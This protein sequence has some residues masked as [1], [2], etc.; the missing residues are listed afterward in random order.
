MDDGSRSAREPRLSILDRPHRPRVVIGRCS[1]DPTPPS[2]TRD[3][4]AR[5]EPR[6]RA[7]RG[8][9]KK[10]GFLA[11]ARRQEKKPGDPIAGSAGRDDAHLLTVLGG[12][13]ALGGV[14]GENRPRT[15]TLSP[16]DAPHPESVEKGGG[17]GGWRSRQRCAPLGTAKK[18]SPVTEVA[19]RAACEPTRERRRAPRTRERRRTTSRRG[20]EAHLAACDTTSGPYALDKEGDAR[21]RVRCFVDGQKK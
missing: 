16:D 18:T 6:A 12:A 17:G 10:S 7:L 13:L 3:R 15:L 21:A 14:R 8:T 9:R 4:D 1:A 11:A 20:H 19:G 2:E 5:T